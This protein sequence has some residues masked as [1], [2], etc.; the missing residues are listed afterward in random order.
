MNQDI[1]AFAQSIGS[2]RAQVGRAVV[3]Q[4]ETV[5]L[6]LATLFAGGHALLE[7][8]PGT[9]KTL[10]VRALAAA[11]S[12]K[13]NRIQFTPDMM[14]SDITGTNVFQAQRGVF[15]IVKG[16]V[17][18][19]LLLADEI[20]R[21]PPKTQAALLE[22]MQER[23]VTLDGTR[24]ALSEC[25]TVFATQNPVEFE[26]TYPLPEAQRDRF[27]LWISVGYPE[28]GDEGEILRRI[29]RGEDLAGAVVAGIRPCLDAAGV[30][31][32]RALVGRVL[33]DE[34]ILAYTAKMVRETRRH[35]AVLLGAG[36]RGSVA[37]LMAS[38]AWAAIQ[39]RDFVTPD[40]VKRMALSVLR[41]RVVLRAESEMEGVTPSEVLK[42][43][44]SRLEVPR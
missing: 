17:F 9:G 8:V 11:L 29:Q 27:L 33:A 40:D 34:P 23:Q 5:D 13:A 25:F 1:E 30:L 15:E 36:P 37:L 10:L 44:C 20:N 14:P 18:T 22:A 6:M 3:G 32:G 35:D 31:A 43:V 19:E 28:E 12:L 41:H 16:P 26:G 39:G 42:E 24:H 38:K 2:V 4:G 21:T 7:G